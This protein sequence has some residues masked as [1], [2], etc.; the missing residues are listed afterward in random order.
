MGWQEAQQTDRSPKNQANSSRA[1]LSPKKSNL[2]TSTLDDNTG[3][4]FFDTSQWKQMYFGGLC[5]SIEG[6][7]KE[8][9]WSTWYLWVRSVTTTPPLINIP[10]GALEFQL[11][12]YPRNNC[13]PLQ[14]VFCHRSLVGGELCFRTVIDKGN[15]PSFWTAVSVKAC[16]SA[17]LLIGCFERL[18]CLML[19]FSWL[20]I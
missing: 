6:L 3:D 18:M 11:S 15:H 8:G 1:H 10:W 20:D 7:S 13:T 12:Y 5:V 19:L 2:S 17:A 4:T 16:Y 9:L 14:P